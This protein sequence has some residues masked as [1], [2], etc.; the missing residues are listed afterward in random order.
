MI[1]CK[2]KLKISIVDCMKIIELFSGSGTLSKEFEKAGHEV[3]SI[4]IRKRKEVCEPSLRKDIL[5]VSIRDI[6]FNEV[7]VIW[8]SPPCD[9]FSKA[10]GDFHWT[11]D[12]QPKTKKCHDHLQILKKCLALIEKLKPKIFFIENPDGKMKFQREITSFLVRNEGMI[13]KINYSAYG[14]Q[15]PKPTNLFT[16]ALDFKPKIIPDTFNKDRGTFQ[17]NNQ[18]IFDNMTKCQRQK[19]PQPLARHILE[20]CT[21]KIEISD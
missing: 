6:P 5:Q 1:G 21:K 9:V 20:Y 2:L 17:K 4:D 3:F 18:L 7:D 15:L 13:K 8:A 14:F 12:N 16:N 11:K 19:I 10:S